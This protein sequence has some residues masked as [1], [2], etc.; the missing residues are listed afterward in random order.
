MSRF[1]STRRRAAGAIALGLIAIA[2]PS[3]A[4]PAGPFDALTGTWTGSGQ[5]R[6]EDGKTEGL[7]CKAYYTP[8][9]G[10]S[11]LGLA[12]RCASAS[13][14]IELRASLSSAGGRVSGDWEE[15]SFNA[16]GTVT[17]QATADSI[18]LSIAGGGFTGSMV[19]K[20]SGGSQSISVA[21]Q[22]SALKGV[23]ITLKRDGS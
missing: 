19:V 13:N 6:L 1:V 23:N 21:A 14:K 11:G 2:L 20:T 7:K 22:G 4:A 8:K 12:L 5:V 16:A 10:G 18:R 3:G 9:S 17:G 15:R